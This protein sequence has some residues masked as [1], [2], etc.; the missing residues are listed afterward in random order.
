M[1]AVLFLCISAV[2]LIKYVFYEEVA[3]YLYEL[4]GAERVALLQDAKPY[5]ADTT[6]FSFGLSAPATKSLELRSYFLLDSL[7]EGAEDT[8]EATLRIAQIPASIRHD[9]PEPRPTRYNA[10]DLWTWAEAHPKGFNCRAHSILLHEL[11]LSVGIANRV[12]TCS[13]QDTTDTDCH[14]V[15][16]VWLPEKKKWVMVDTDKHAYATDEN[17]TVLSLMEMREKLIRE[18]PVEFESF[19]A[20]SIPNKQPLYY[21]WAKNLYYLDALEQQT[22]DVESSPNGHWRKVYLVP[23]KTHFPKSYRPLQDVLTTDEDRFWE[24]PV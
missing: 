1:L 8:W 15:N 17:G 20:D 3:N 5:Q 13:P 9:N 16:A 12:I 10:I 11:L 18:E 6:S 21:Y 22:Y 19:T 24:E 2:L 23:Q 4:E 14:V 7:M